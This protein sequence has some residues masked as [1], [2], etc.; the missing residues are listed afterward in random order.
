[1][2]RALV[3]ANHD[4]LVLAFPGDLF[5]RLGDIIPF[6]TVLYGDF[7]DLHLIQAEINRWKP[8][9]CIYLAWQAELGKYLLVMFHWHWLSAAVHI[10]SE[11]KP[12]L[13][14]R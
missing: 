8:E 14:M 9:T 6:I 2:T 7:H 4:V 5:W 11:S 12:A 10:L 3:K 1:M 13:N